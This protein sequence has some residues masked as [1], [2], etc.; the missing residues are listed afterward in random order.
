VKLPAF[1]LLALWFAAHSHA[2]RLPP[3]ERE[4]LE[5]GE[6]LVTMVEVTGAPVREG[7]ARRLLSATPERVFRAI[8]DY[9]HYAEFMPFVTSSRSAG[10]NAGQEQWEFQLDLPWP[11]PDERFLITAE[12]QASADR[13]TSS[14][15]LVPGSGEVLE[16]RGDWTLEPYGRDRTLVT[17]RMRSHS[18]PP[19]PVGLQERATRDSLPWML[20]GLRQHVGRCRYDEPRAATCTE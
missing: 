13:W 17:L 3:Y 20:D 14:W 2:E 9:A 18:G 15:R 12:S 8:S 7:V 1:A 10:Q 19:I 6:T 11:S 5:A 16:N 4:R